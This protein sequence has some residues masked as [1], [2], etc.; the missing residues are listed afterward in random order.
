MGRF[1]S[2]IRPYDGQPPWN[3]ERFTGQIL[4]ATAEYYRVAWVNKDCTIYIP[5]E[6]GAGQQYDEPLWGW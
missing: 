2:I 1:N 5:K 4:S 6:I 3:P